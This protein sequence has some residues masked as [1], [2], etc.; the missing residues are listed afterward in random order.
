MEQQ[1][2]LTDVNLADIQCIFSA[3]NFFILGALQTWKYYHGLPRY[4]KIWFF[5]LLCYCL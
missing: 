5:A 2:K 3:P 1:G 4:V